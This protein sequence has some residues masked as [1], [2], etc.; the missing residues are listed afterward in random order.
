MQQTKA[1][2]TRIQAAAY[3]YLTESL[4]ETE[5]AISDSLATV[6]GTREKFQALVGS[7]QDSK[8]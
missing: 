6:A 5:K 7:K 8:E 1:E 3:Q 2:M 4:K